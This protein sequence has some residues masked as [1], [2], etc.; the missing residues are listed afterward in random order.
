MCTQ[1]STLQF[2]AGLKTNIESFVAKFESLYSDVRKL[3]GSKC[4]EEVTY[5]PLVKRFLELQSEYDVPKDAAL[6]M[7]KSIKV[8][9]SEPKKKSSAKKPK[10]D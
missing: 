3:V 6:G 10:L 8:R 5:V 4:N 9:K 7:T 2:G 1:L